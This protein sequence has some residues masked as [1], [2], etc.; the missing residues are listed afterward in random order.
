M[1]RSGT[2]L[3]QVNHGRS[4]PFSSGLIVVFMT[5][6]VVGWPLSN[7]F[8]HHCCVMI[9]WAT[10]VF[11][12]ATRRQVTCCRVTGACVSSNDSFLKRGV[13]GVGDSVASSGNE[14][15]VITC[16]ALGARWVRLHYWMRQGMRDGKKY[17]IPVHVVLVKWCA[18]TKEGGFSYIMSWRKAISNI[19]C[20][21]RFSNHEYGLV[22]QD[23]S[24][25][26][27]PCAWEQVGWKG[28]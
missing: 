26:V 19:G 18:H 22:M 13:V 15:E 14:F 6:L 3:W 5:N 11:H 25:R 10:R 4:W 20:S 2:L 17:I 8:D 1:V 24:M 28:T 9:C 21:Y 12:R 7:I 16:W 27:G 23:G